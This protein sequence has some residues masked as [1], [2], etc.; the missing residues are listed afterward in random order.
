MGLWVYVCV[1]ARAC[2]LLLIVVLFPPLSVSAEG[3]KTRQ[4][5][6]SS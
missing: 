2:V 3:F 4:H 6:Y 5:C 1:C